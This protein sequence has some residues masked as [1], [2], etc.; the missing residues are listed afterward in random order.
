M[1]SF[2]RSDEKVFQALFF[3]VAEKNKFQLKI[4]NED[5]QT[6]FHCFMLLLWLENKYLKYVM[7]SRPLFLIISFLFCY[8]MFEGFYD[9]NLLQIFEG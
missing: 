1:R 5:D 8:S 4:N 9:Y 3:M 7:C 6:P 2:T